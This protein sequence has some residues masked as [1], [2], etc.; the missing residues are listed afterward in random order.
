MPSRHRGGAAVLDPSGPAQR[1]TRLCHH[2]KI[3]NFQILPCKDD[4]QTFFSL[5][6]GNTRFSDLIQLVD[7]YQLK[8]GSYLAD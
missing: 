2:Q 3:K 6:N 1:W 7:F 5:D 4:G 8:K